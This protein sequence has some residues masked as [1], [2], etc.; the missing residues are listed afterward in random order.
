L[1]LAV[2]AL[3]E[4]EADEL[5]LGLLASQ[6]ACGLVVEVVELPLEDRDDMARDVLVDLGILERAE[7]ALAVLL[8]AGVLLERRR[9]DGLLRL[10][11]CAVRRRGLLL[12]L[13]SGDG[14][15]RSGSFRRRA[16]PGG[17]AGSI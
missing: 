4:P 1:A 2:D 16:L 9:V 6:K 5:V 14:L 8:L 12:G 15:H 11:G 10:R 7:L 3:L 17:A 13:W